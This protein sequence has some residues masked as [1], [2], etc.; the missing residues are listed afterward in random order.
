MPNAHVW[1]LVLSGGG[2]VVGT[3][4]TSVKDPGAVWCLRYC[5]ELRNKEMWCVCIYIY[6]QVVIIT[7]EPFSRRCLIDFVI[8]VN[9]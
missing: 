3:S 1:C 8:N 5:A 9:F 4:K 2:G 7:T 6:N